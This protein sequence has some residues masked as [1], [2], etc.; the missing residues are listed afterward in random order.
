MNKLLST[1]TALAFAMVATG[2]AA[3]DVVVKWLHQQNDPEQR[4]YYEELAARQRTGSVDGEGLSDE[5]LGWFPFP[6]VPG[7][8][9]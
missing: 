3:E 7:G 5:E 9:G 1:V 2:A 8:A 4:A 6:T